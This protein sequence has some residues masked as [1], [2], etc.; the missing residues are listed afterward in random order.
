MNF[1]KVTKLVNM[2]LLFMGITVVKLGTG[3]K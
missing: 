3:E 1:F 2:M